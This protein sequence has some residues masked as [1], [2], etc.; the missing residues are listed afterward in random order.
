VRTGGRNPASAIRFR[1]GL[2]DY[3]VA[4]IRKLKVERF[5]SIVELELELGRMNVFIGANGSGK[6][7]LLEALGVLGAASFGRV[8]DETLLRRGVRP[9]VPKLYKTAFPSS[10]KVPRILFSATPETGATYEANLWNPIDNPDPAWRYMSERLE[11]GTT[12]IAT[13]GVKGRTL[14][15]EQRIA[16]L[17]TVTLPP[18][19]P[20][21]VLMDELRALRANIAETLRRP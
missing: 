3:K 4:M 12:T 11:R 13:P 1:N 10:Q 15:Q 6:S 17:Q 9:G 20:A 14:N 16:A 7:S 18:G 5:K 8:D 2:R 19:D 21:L